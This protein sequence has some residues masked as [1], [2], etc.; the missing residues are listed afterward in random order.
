MTNRR[1]RRPLPPELPEPPQGLLSPEALG[2]LK[3]LDGDPLS[4]GFTRERNR[5]ILEAAI[6]YASVFTQF[7][8]L[9]EQAEKYRKLRRQNSAAQRR[10]KTK[11]DQKEERHAQG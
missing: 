7:P 3:V 9:W 5:E 2:E 6:F 4:R 1:G 11:T 10:W 8:Q